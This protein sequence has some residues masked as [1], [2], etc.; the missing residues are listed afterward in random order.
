ML[1]AVTLPDGLDD[2]A[3]RKRLLL[4]HGI[5][6][7]AGLGELKGRILRV[8]LM[9]VNANRGAVVRFVAAFEESLR[10][11]GRSPVRRRRG[12]GADGVEES[13]RG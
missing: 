8:G 9:G 3:L 6:V 11:C 2:A 7:G 13:A 12:R 4:E 1:N 5:E 10:S